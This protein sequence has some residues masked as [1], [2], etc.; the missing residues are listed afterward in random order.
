MYWSGEESKSQEKQSNELM[1]IIILL[2]LLFKCDRLMI[3]KSIV[4]KEV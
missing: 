3:S 2:V 4:I 1:F